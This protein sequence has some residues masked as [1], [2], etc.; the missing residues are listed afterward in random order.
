MLTA[1]GCW[2]GAAAGEWPR[3][4]PASAAQLGAGPGAGCCADLE[5]R[6]AELEASVARRGNRKVSLEVHGQVSEV[7]MWWNDGAA[8]KRLIAA[9]RAVP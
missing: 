4:A 1:A 5:E 6:I 8:K 7:E 3:I 9:S 2:I